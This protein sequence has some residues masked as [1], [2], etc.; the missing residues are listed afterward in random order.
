MM[1]LPEISSKEGLSLPYAGK[2]MMKLKKAGLVKAVR[3]RNGG[4]TICRPASEIYLK[5]VLSALGNSLYGSHHCDRYSSDKEIC[6][7]HNN[8]KVGTLWGFFN[9]QI[10]S[11]IEKVTLADVA[12]GNLNFTKSFNV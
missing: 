6:R 7:H 12:S 1:T 9:Q 4:F 5:E 10:E 8:C 11:A 2:L 3:G